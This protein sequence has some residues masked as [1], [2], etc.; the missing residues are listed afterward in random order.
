MVD[1]KRKLPVMN[2][3]KTVADKKSSRQKKV[4]SVIIMA[5]TEK[6]MDLGQDH[7]LKP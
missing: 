6:E 5:N 1:I 3:V 4:T 2:P 7:S